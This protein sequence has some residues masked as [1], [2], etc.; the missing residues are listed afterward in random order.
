MKN[1]V[2]ICLKLLSTTANAVLFTSSN[3]FHWMQNDLNRIE[4]YEGG[5]SKGYLIGI[6]NTLS[7]TMP[8]T[9]Y[10]P[11]GISAMKLKMVVYDYCK[12]TLI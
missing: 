6:L 2:I 9:V 12:I 11:S 1:S 10:Y 8:R 7:N 3:L 5:M 4:T